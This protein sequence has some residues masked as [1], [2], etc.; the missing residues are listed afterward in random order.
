M[1]IPKLQLVP[2]PRPQAEII[3][4]APDTLDFTKTMI[5]NREQLTEAHADASH[6]SRVLHNAENLSDL[7]IS[8]LVYLCRTIYHAT[9]ILGAMLSAPEVAAR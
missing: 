7:D 9:E 1:S 5:V 6:V 3:T 4:H 8:E 2:Q